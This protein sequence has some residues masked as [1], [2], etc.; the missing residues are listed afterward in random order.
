MKGMKKKLLAVIAAMTMLC[1]TLAGCGEQ[2]AP[3]DQTVSALFELAAKSNAAP[4]KDLLGFASEEDVRS[5]FFEEGADT[6]LIDDLRSEL[7]A[8]GIEMSDEDIQE[9]TDSMLAMLA[10]ITYT[11]EIASEDKE[12]TVVTLKVNGYSSDAM[13]DIMMDAANAMV[14]SLTEEDQLAIAN[15]DTDVFNAYM[16]QYL[17]D[18]MNGLSALEPNADPVEISVTCE[19]LIV[20]V[21]GKEKIAWLPS[22]MDGFSS[23][24]EAAMFQ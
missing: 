13:T 23:D 2:L 17:K 11:A 15:G 19:K 3:A 12:T 1:M 21:S 16:Q 18:F 10:K 24:I 9:F 4:M 5:A 20:E 8:A 7:T 22:D 6:E 14:E